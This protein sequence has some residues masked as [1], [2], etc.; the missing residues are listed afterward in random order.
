MSHPRSPQSFGTHLIL[1]AWGA[2]PGVLDDPGLL[3]EALKKAIAAGRATLINLCVHQF[4]PHGVTATATLEESHVAI[5]TW[6]EHAYFAADLFFCASGEP[7]L[8][9]QALIDAIQPER[10]E[11]KKVERGISMPRRQPQLID[12]HAA[13]AR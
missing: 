11:V 3:T 13:S 12:L 5:H 8:A 2:D 1:D 6:P 9:M 4:S 7:E 10:Y